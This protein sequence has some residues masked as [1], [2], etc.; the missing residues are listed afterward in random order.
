MTNL[1]SE[2]NV[3]LNVYTNK[4]G[5]LMFHKIFTVE[6]L[7]VIS[8]FVM[9][10]VVW[11]LEPS[12]LEAQSHLHLLCCDIKLYFSSTRPGSRYRGL[13]IPQGKKATV[14]LC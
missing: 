11:K 13:D 7:Q 2:D 5:K 4:E 8:D 9:N 6:S 1:V 14:L 10:R 3:N 12:V